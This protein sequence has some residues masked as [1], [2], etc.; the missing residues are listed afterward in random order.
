MLDVLSFLDLLDE[1]LTEDD[2]N[3]NSDSGRVAAALTRLGDIVDSA[4]SFRPP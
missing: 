4:Q 2:R 1:I 3:Q